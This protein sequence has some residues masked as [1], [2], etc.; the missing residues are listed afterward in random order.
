MGK[1][2]LRF[3]VIVSVVTLLVVFK[4]AQICTHQKKAHRH[5]MMC[6]KLHFYERYHVSLLISFDKHTI[7]SN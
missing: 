7:P 4:Q 6:N 3:V 2:I 5:H 1:G